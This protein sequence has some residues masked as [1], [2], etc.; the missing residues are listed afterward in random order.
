[1]NKPHRY[2]Y[3]LEERPSFWRRARSYVISAVVVSLIL[4]GAF[5]AFADGP[6]FLT[7]SWY[8]VESLK[9][10]GTFKTSKGV[11]A[12]GQM[13]KDENLTAATR[14]WPLGTRLVVR[15]VRTNR[16]VLVTVTDRIGRRFETKRIDL[17][18]AAFAQIAQL[19]AG[20]VSVEVCPEAESG[21]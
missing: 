18:K 10:E 5:L 19:S 12:N 8:S 20:L 14:L 11:M 4:L 1:M 3:G 21:K 17:S 13:F 2:G 6:V 7:A 15:N 9:R 16:R